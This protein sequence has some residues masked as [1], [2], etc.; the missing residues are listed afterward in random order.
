MKIYYN[1]KLKNRAKELRKNATF[2]ER[3]LWKH[4]K[5]RQMMGY[6]F[7]RQK[8]IGNYIV[9]LYCSKLHLVI[10]I[11]GVSHNDKQRY[12]KKRDNELRALGLEVLHFDGYYVI[13]NPSGTLEI[14]IA[15]IRKLENRTTPYPPLL[16]GE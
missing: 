4:L 1:P 16:R 9:D 8:P 2:S 15:K 12:D 13:N 7:M 10:E 3:C 11:D 5:A 14:I 6:Q